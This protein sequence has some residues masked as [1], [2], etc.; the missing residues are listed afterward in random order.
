MYIFSLVGVKRGLVESSQLPRCRSSWTKSSALRGTWGALW[1]WRRCGPSWYWTWETGGTSES[2]EIRA[3]PTESPFPIKALASG[4]EIWLRCRDGEDCQWISIGEMV[5]WSSVKDG[6]DKWR[7][8]WTWP[9]KGNF[10][11]L[12]LCDKILLHNW[13]KEND[14]LTDLIVTY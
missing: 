3:H 14:I 11:W 5:G 6:C 12:G 9:G 2:T 1:R 8:T 13:I 4:C 10:G 7:W